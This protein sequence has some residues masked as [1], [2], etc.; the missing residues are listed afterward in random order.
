[1]AAAR[2]Q[3]APLIAGGGSE[4]LSCSAPVAS[5]PPGKDDDHE[6]MRVPT[7]RLAGD[8]PAGLQEGSS[9]SRR[10]RRPRSRWRPSCR[11]TSRS[12]V[13]AIGQTRGST[14]IEVR[15]RVEGFPPDR[16]LH[17]RHPR[18]QGPA[19]LHARTR[20]PSR[21]PW[22]RPGASSPGP[23]RTWRGHIRTW[24]AE[25]LVAQE[26][27]LRQEY[28]TAVAVERAAISRRG[29]GQGRSPAG[30]IDSLH[31][32]PGA[33]ERPGWED[34]GVPGHPG[35]PGAEHAPHPA[36]RRS[37][38]STSA[39]RSRSGTPVLRT[40]PGGARISAKPVELPFELG[41]R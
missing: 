25:P 19:P 7:P 31:Q 41:A 3:Q 8:Q 37:G 9:S 28:E 29:R 13:E 14:E 36:S 20:S 38:R 12:Y 39:S 6:A 2:G 35:G 23:R 15:A 4:R 1:M 17:G 30:E 27:D 10:R 16:Q 21:P 18:P 5:A 22:P 11:R 32:G 40:P 34:R 26:R 24:C 33:R